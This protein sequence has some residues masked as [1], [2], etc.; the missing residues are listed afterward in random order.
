VSNVGK[1]K[2]EVLA[3]LAAFKK[4][5]GDGGGHVLQ[6]PPSMRIKEATQTVTDISKAEHFTYPIIAISPEFRRVSSGAFMAPYD[7]SPMGPCVF[8]G[9]GD[10]EDR[11]G[12]SRPLRA[13]V[14]IT[15][16]RSTRQ[17]ESPPVS[18]M[19]VVP[20]DQEAARAT[21]GGGSGVIAKIVKLPV[22]PTAAI[23][24]AERVAALFGYIGD[25]CVYVYEA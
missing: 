14:P 5:G 8:E 11:S 1:T 12:E 15:P 21:S 4:T 19:E 25:L 6:C 22:N 7:A 18:V 16:P 2:T 20:W 13:P 17:P 3:S 10:S 9:G 23:T 24:E